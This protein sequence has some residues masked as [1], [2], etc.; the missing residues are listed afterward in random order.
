MKGFRGKNYGHAWISNWHLA[1]EG[2]RLGEQN[3]WVTGAGPNLWILNGLKLTHWICLP[4]A[5]DEGNALMDVYGWHAPL[6]RL[7]ENI[8]IL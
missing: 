5:Q 8:E 1:Q 3:E 2:S 4:Y 7:S 6:S